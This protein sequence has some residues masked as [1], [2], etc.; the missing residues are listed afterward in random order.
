MAIE[1]FMSFCIWQLWFKKKKKLHLKTDGDY[2]HADTHTHSFSM[3]LFHQVSHF[4]HLYYFVPRVPPFDHFGNCSITR[5]S[6]LQ[7][8]SSAWWHEQVDADTEDMN[9]Y[10]NHCEFVYNSGV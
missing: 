3:Q 1:N 7:A 2:L 4:I 10:I 5:L 8:P 6:K 9:E